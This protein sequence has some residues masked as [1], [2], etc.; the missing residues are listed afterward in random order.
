MCGRR[1]R[2]KPDCPF[3]KVRSGCGLFLLKFPDH[4]AVVNKRHSSSSNSN[5][6]VLSPCQSL[7]LLCCG[8]CLSAVG[9]NGRTGAHCARDCCRQAR[10]GGLVRQVW[11]WTPFVL[12]TFSEGDAGE[13]GVTMKIETLLLLCFCVTGEF[14]THR[15]PHR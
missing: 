11:D 5:P 4:H 13:C 7:C 3:N 1:I 12:F 2:K 8:L 14:Y 15:Y 10:A 6:E 9:Y